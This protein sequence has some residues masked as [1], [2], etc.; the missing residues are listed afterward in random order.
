[1]ATGT[2]PKIIQMTTGGLTSS[3]QSYS[4]TG[5]TPTVVKLISSNAGQS[6]PQYI[7]G[8]NA[9][10]Q[11]IKIAT[12]TSGISGSQIIKTVPQGSFQLAKGGKIQGA[13]VLNQ[14]GKQIIVAAPKGQTSQA[15]TQ[16]LP[17]GS[18]VK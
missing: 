9:Q 16:I 5:K 4:A 8:F 15:G 7:Q 11:P 14:G 6:A 1:M 10:G 13:Q 12:G 3:I 18:I 17:G 2:V